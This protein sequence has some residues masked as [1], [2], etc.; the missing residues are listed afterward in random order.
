M[1]GSS[2]ILLGA[3]GVG[4]THATVALVAEYLQVAG[5]CSTR[6]VT[7][8]D[9]L[10]ELRGCYNGK[11]DETDVINKYTKDTKILIL[12][13]IGAE[14]PSEWTVATLG[15]I[16]DRRY[17]DN[18]MTLFTSN[19]TMQELSETVGDRITS[20]I[21]GLCGTNI[22]KLNGGDRRRVSNDRYN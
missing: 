21:L 13:D 12:D 18:M 17:R 8:A 15:L 4:K 3:R 20:R 10:L 1:V 22:A 16:I 11:A 14:K 6:F 2:V 9:L 5:L 7:A 19:L